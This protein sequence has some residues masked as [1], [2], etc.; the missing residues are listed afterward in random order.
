[1]LMIIYTSFVM[2]SWK[3][4]LFIIWLAQVLSLSGFGFMLPFLPYYIQTLGVENP[5][6]LRVWV[7]LLT[8]G[9]ALTMG[10][11]APVWGLLADC[12]GKKMMMVRSF[13][14]GTLVVFLMGL[15]PNAETVLI[16]RVL[17]GMLT[18]TVTAAAAP[19]SFYSSFYS[20]CESSGFFRIPLSPCM[21]RTLSVRSGERLPSWGR[22]PRAEACRR[23]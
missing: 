11:M 21:C 22:S 15:A 14:A 1:M 9:P 5:V 17:Q 8:S 2:R 19:L 3:R 6:Q 12:F 10:L 23:R 7:G 13:S 20:A 18:G 16:L 4:N